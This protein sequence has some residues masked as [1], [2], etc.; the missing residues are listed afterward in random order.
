[1]SLTLAGDSLA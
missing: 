1:M